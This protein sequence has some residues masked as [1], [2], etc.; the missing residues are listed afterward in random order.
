MKTLSAIYKGNRTVQLSE[1]LDLPDNARVLVVIPEK[2]EDELRA[3]FMKAAEK[4]FN[5]IWDH[6]EDEVWNEY[7][8]QAWNSGKVR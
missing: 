7:L 3:D 4:S 1:D 6:K 8:E 5:K 2:D